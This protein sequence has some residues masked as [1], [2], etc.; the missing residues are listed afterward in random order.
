MSALINNLGIDWKLLLSQAVNFALL[1]IVLRFTIYKPLLDMM[2]K[3]RE[4]IEEGLT[5]AEEADRRLKEVTEIQKEKIKEAEVHGLTIVK[6]AQAQ[7]EEERVKI[8]V[9][10]KAEEETM[11]KIAEEKI[12]AKAE[13]SERR[14]QSEA[15]QLVK[16]ILVKTVDLDPK[17]IDDALIERATKEAKM[18]H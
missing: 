18:S 10:A 4:R 13:E 9:A 12:R 1:L 15:A 6:F 17:K 16:A 11:I 5:K 8:L 14:V 7:G 3:R 2:R